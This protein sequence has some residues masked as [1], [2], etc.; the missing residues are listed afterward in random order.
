[1]GTER[2]LKFLDKIDSPEK[3]IMATIVHVTGTNG[4]GSVVEMTATGLAHLGK[5]VGAFTSPFLQYE[6]DSIR[7]F[8]EENSILKV[9]SIPEKEYEK[10][11]GGIFSTKGFEE[12]PLTEFEV[13]VVCCLV[14][15]ARVQ[16]VDVLIMEVGMGGRDDATNVFRHRPTTCVLTGVSWDHEKFLGDTLEKICENKCGIVHRDCNVVIGDLPADLTEFARNECLR[17]G[18]VA[19]ETLAKETVDLMEPPLNGSHQ[20]F[21]TAVVYTVLSKIIHAD[22]LAVIAA[23]GRTKLPGRL[24]RR[25]DPKVAFPLILDG[26]H[27]IESATALR[28]F[29]DD[30]LDVSSKKTVTWLLA[31]SQ[32]RERILPQLL[33]P[34]EICICIKFE[35]MQN[36]EWV[37]CVD[38]HELGKIAD[39]LGCVTKVIDG[40]VGEGLEYIRKSPDLENKL[41]V[42]AGSLYLVRNYLRYI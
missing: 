32:N 35:S 18:A 15:F 33:R 1:M 22:P 13:S 30:E 24:E 41:V 20:R 31:T 37:K 7:T 8:K 39:S 5:T 2:I 25:Y 29:I 14:F 40:Y 21:L 34:G 16:P 42:V 26:A 4:K 38:P 6:T 23:I 9:F 12:D 17:R 3:T 11:R 27:N 10:I 19:V 36:S 28:K